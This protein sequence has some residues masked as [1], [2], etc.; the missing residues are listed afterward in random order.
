MKV[1]ICGAGRVGYAIASYLADEGN[2][3]I[4]ID[5]CPETVAKINDTLD[6]SAIVGSGSQPEIL[7]HAGAETADMIVAATHLDEVNMVTC[8]VAH[9]IF[10]IPKKIARIRD[11]NYLSPEWA[12]LF[13]RN[14][15]PI[16]VVIS[17]EKEV[18]RAIIERIRNPGSFNIIPLAGE[19]MKLVSVV[20]HNNCPI[21]NT[22]IKQIYALFPDLKFKIMA[23]IRGDEKIL[24][25][26]DLEQIFEGDEVYFVVAS[27]HMTRTMAAFGH[28]EKE[29]RRILIIGGGQIG[30]RLSKELYKEFPDVAVRMIERDER[31]AK[32]ISE[33]LPN[34]LVMHG[35]ALTRDILEEAN[36][37]YTEATI[38]VTDYDESNI[39]ASVLAHEYGCQQTI[40]LL[41]NTTYIPVASSLGIDAVVNPR[42]VTI[43]TILRYVRHGRIR[44]AS[45]LR[46]GFAEVIEIEVPDIATA[47]L[48]KPLKS[49]KLPENTI[50]GAIIRNEEIIIAHRDVMIKP[51][52]RVVLLTAHNQIKR[53][54]ELFS[55]LEADYL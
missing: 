3:V 28:E 48:Y 37:G 20:C 31:R 54:E 27:E 42:A 24:P 41:S 26:N 33:I 38:T 44:S 52:D 46:D 6:I 50:F 21:L 7:K 32:Q 22:P 34:V 19:A 36:I 47:L 16:D 45:S 43:S 14:H 2:E 8:Q 15:M 39:L 12:N 40:S 30:V 53:I 35:N 9:T 1:I 18:A 23:I 5:I 13:S 11:E 49:I 51:N 10:N 25:N 17:P 29:A 4:V 55:S